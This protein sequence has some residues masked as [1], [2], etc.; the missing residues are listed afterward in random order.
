MR[1][2]IRE[3]RRVKASELRPSSNNWRIHSSFQRD[4]LRAVLDEVGMAAALI[5]RE[6]PDGSLTLIDGHLRADMNG[7]EVVP[8]LIVDLDDAETDKVMLTLDPLSALAT[9]DAPKLDALLRSVQTPS[10]DLA[11]MLADLAVAN[12][13]IPP[14]AQ[15]LPQPDPP[16]SFPSYDENI[17][18]D[19]ECPK[20]GFKWAS[21]KK[22]S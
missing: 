12:N 1:D 16:E 2:R 22:P 17:A 18:T 6:M 4:S 5:A 3:L 9:A 10:S 15:P 7:D 11:K 20:C 8:V 13:L 19:C 21:G 14:E